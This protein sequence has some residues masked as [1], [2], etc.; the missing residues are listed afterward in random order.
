[1]NFLVSLLV[2]LSFVVGNGGTERTRTVIGLV[3]NQVPH[4]SATVP[5]SMISS[6]AAKCLYIVVTKEF[7]SSVRSLMFSAAHEWLKSLSERRGL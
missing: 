6:V 7:I 1:M 4:L 2:L 3:D 5:K